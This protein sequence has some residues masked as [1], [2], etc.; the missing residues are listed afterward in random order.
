MKKCFLAGPILLAAILLAGCA[1]GTIGSEEPDDSSAPPTTS[2]SPGHHGGED[3][4]GSNTPPDPGA[5]VSADEATV[6]YVDCLNEHGLNAVIGPD[7]TAQYA[8]TEEDLGEDGQPVVPG[9][10]AE[11][12]GTEALCQ[13]TVPSYTPPDYNER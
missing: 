4:G 2:A 3:S 6:E 11:Q 13:D 7:G 12:A 8:V 9:D 5:S 10:D 1:P